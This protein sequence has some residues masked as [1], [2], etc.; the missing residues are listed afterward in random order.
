MLTT[1]RHKMRAQKFVG[2]AALLAAVLLVEL[3]A[4]QHTE[5]DYRRHA[6]TTKSAV[7]P[8][9]AGR[10]NMLRQGQ[11]S[12]QGKDGGCLHRRLADDS[13]KGISLLFT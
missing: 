11:C 13:Q 9:L 10:R 6:F 4:S 7:Q 3:T 2:L 8:H 1:A 12:R 5:I